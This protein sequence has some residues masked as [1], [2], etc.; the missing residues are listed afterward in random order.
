[1]QKKIALSLL[2]LMALI[3]CSK[4]SEAPVYKK[5]E[6]SFL[7]LFDTVTTVVGYAEGEEEFR[8]LSQNIHDELLYYHQLYDIY[9]DYEGVNNIKTINDSAGVKPVVVDRAIIDL[10]LF[11]REMQKE[12]ESVNVAFGSVLSLWHIERENV[13]SGE[14]GKLPSMEA[15]KEASLHTDFSSI[16]I[17][18]TASTVYLPD[19][20]MR[21]DVGAV[22]KGYATERVIRSVKGIYLLSVGGNVS[23]SSPKPEDKPWVVGLQDV[24]GD[25]GQN[26]HTLYL[27]KGAVV[28]SGT[29]QRF[30]TVDGKE[31]HHIIDPNTLMPGTKWKAV[32]VIAPDSGIA[33]FLST[34]LF[35]L[36]VEEGQKLL[37]KYSAVALWTDKDGNEIMSD[38]FKA[39]MRT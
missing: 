29:Y 39:I 38:G 27:E 37:T 12:T 4:S 10:L 21:L 11:C 3:S 15:L 13:L 23:A 30:Y 9:N 16:Q 20:K 31:Y 1:M 6:A 25:I 17:D 5:Y 34:A 8:A 14:E 36:D 22:A 18:E 19:P 7:S 32:S 35:L 26:K 2:I 33:D 28:T 24:N